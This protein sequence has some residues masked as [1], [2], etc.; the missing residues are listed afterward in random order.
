MMIRYNHFPSFFR[1]FDELFRDVNATTAATVRTVTPAADVVE[2]EQAIELRLDLPGVDPEKIDVTLEGHE[3][4][5]AAARVSTGAPDEKSTWLRQERSQAAFK[6]TFTLPES[7]DGTKPEASFKHGVLTV[8]LP[9]K[10][11]ERPRSLKV[12]VEA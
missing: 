2:R 9:R 7:I 6:R 11:A 3:L 8:T 12:K 4:T 1:E 10:E 5:I